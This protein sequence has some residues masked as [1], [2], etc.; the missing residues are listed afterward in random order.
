MTEGN[1]YYVYFRNNLNSNQALGQDGGKFYSPAIGHVY[2][3]PQFFHQ[4]RGILGPGMSLQGSG[5]VGDFFR[6]LFRWSQPL[7][8]N[9]GKK[10]VDSAAGFATNVAK[11]ALEGQN[12]LESVKKHGAVEGRQLLS[13]VPQEVGEFFAGTSTAPQGP[14]R[15]ATAGRNAIRASNKRGLSKK[16]TGKG[17]KKQRGRGAFYSQLY[18][19]LKFMNNFPP[20]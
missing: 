13:E 6:S 2:A 18:P 9:L 16:K 20:L 1:V 10:V 11:D 3:S 4:G 19:A 12:I 14:S 17:A 7:L 15:A 8:T 5:M